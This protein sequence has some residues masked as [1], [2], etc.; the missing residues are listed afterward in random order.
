MMAAP[1]N[2]FLCPRFRA[3]LCDMLPL[4]E[5]AGWF[6]CPRFQAGLCDKQSEKLLELLCAF[7]CPRFRT[8]LRGASGGYMMAAPANCFLSP[9]FRAG[10]CGFGGNS[11]E[12]SSCGTAWG[13]LSAAVLRRT[14]MDGGDTRGAEA[15]GGLGAGAAEFGEAG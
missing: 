8:G 12:L 1:A 14:V 2:W 11:M 7:L 15:V 3:G 9:R 6:L 5:P 10:L 4:Y 13:W